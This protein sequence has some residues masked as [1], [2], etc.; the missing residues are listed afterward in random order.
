LQVH[1][2]GIGGK[3]DPARLV[4]NVPAG[5]AVNAALMDLG[6][7]FRLLVA[8]VDAVKAV[9]PMPKLPVARALWKCRPDFETACAAWIY[10]GGAHHTGFSQAVTTEMLDDFAVMA[11]IEAVVIDADTKLRRFKRELFWDDCAYSLKSSWGS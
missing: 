11:G 1:P 9:Q 6:N 8:E 3:A 10:A 4:F 2:L 7:R 5:P